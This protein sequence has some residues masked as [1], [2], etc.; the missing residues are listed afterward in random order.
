LA[1]NHHFEAAGFDV[2][3][4]KLLNRCAHRAAA[5][6]LNNA[7]SMIGI[8]N[9]IANVEIQVRNTHDKAP[10]KA[11]VRGRKALKT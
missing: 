6:L 7:D 5:N 3:E 1:G 4:V 10:R 2:K 8:D 11:K 9:L